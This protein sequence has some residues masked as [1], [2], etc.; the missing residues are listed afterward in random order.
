MEKT[1]LGKYR[2]IE[3]EKGLKIELGG[4]HTVLFTEPGKGE[5]ND[6]SSIGFG[7]CGCEISVSENAKGLKYHCSEMSFGVTSGAAVAIADLNSGVCRAG[8]ESVGRGGEVSLILLLG[9]DFSVSSMARA[10]ITAVEAIT[11]VIQDL[12]LRDSSGRYG[13]GVDNLRMAVVSDNGSPLHLRGTGKHSK[14]GEIIGKTVY[15][16][17]INSA[18]KNGADHPAEEFIIRTLESKGHPVKD[19]PPEKLAVLHDRKMIAAF[20]SLNLLDD[21]IEWG[22]IPKK[23]GLEVGSKIIKSILGHCSSGD[24]LMA[25][26][27]SSL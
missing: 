17:V 4:N 26:F 18:K 1:I 11:A 25:M 6:V 2:L 10:G 12:D 21:E 24:D 14:M 19:L 20:S 27:V 16:A 9:P 22:L 5:Y 13:S 23:E 8:C 3:N 15:D 7:D